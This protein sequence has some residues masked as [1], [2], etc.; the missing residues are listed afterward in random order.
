MQMSLRTLYRKL[1]KELKLLI[2]KKLLEVW[3][4]T[5]EDYYEVKTPGIPAFSIIIYHLHDDFNLELAEELSQSLS[6]NLPIDQALIKLED[7]K[8]SGVLR[9]HHSELYFK[10][11]D[12]ILCRPQEIYHIIESIRA[13]IAWGLIHVLR[14]QV[15]TSWIIMGPQGQ[16]QKLPNE[17]YKAIKH[18]CFIDNPYQVRLKLDFSERPKSASQRLTVKKWTKVKKRSYK[19]T[20]Y[21]IRYPNFLEDRHLILDQKKENDPWFNWSGCFGPDF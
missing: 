15:W 18:Y 20:L 6:W 3:D 10:A 5:W 17:M 2:I 1:P 21:K 4:L 13:L 14:I 8:K 7:A 11:T 9:F 12:A 16:F 19:R